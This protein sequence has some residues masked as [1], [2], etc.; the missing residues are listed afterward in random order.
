MARI[1]LPCRGAGC[2]TGRGEEGLCIS[3]M[4]II[5]HQIHR[6]SN[7]SVLP[8]SAISSSLAV[9]ARKRVLPVEFLV[10]IS[11]FLSWLSGAYRFSVL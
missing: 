4:A 6:S 2:E 5:R 8:A 1:A 7:Y 9:L 10:L 3:I 11:G